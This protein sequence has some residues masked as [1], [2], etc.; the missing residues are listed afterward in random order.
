MKVKLFI[1]FVSTERQNADPSSY[2]QMTQNV[3][4]PMDGLMARGPMPL[5]VAEKAPEKPT[6][7]APTGNRVAY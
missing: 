5:P 4:S 1:T 2:S 6:E 3:G 7:H